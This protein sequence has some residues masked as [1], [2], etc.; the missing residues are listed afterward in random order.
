[1]TRRWREI[2]RKPR[3]RAATRTGV[4]V[5]GMHRSGTSALARVL[6]LAGCDLPQTLVEAKPDNVAGF[7]ESP[8]IV[9]LNDAILASAGSCWDDWRPFERGWHESPAAGPFRERAMEVLR[10]E[11]GESRLFVLKDPRICRLLPFWTDALTA[12]DLQPCVVAPIRSPLD[13]AASL[14]ARNGI[15]PFVAY[16]IW[17]R[18][19]LAAEADSRGLPRVHVRYDVLLSDVSA[20][21]DRIGGGLGLALPRR[22]APGTAADIDAFLSR[23][24]RHHRSVDDR[25]L[26]DEDISAWV[27]STFRVLERW[28]RGEVDAADAG[29]LDRIRA[30]F[31]AA[32]PAFGRALA[33]GQEAGRER[34]RLTRELLNVSQ[35]LETTRKAFRE[36]D[37][38]LDAQN[39]RLAENWKKLE[40]ARHAL[41]ERNQQLTTARKQLEATRRT[42]A[43]RGQQL[44]ATRQELAAARQELAA[45]GKALEAARETAAG[46]SARIAALAADLD[47]AR[48]RH[49]LALARRGPRRGCYSLE[50]L[51]RPTPEWLAEARGRGPGPALE[52][53]RNGRVLARPALPDGA[54]D[55]LRIPIARS[56]RGVA[57]ALYSVHDAATGAVLA[58]LAAPR[59]GARAPWRERSR[60]ARG[61]RF[62]A[63]CS[64]RPTPGGGGA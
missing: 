2:G 6:T 1:M 24:L 20:A 12:L 14:A 10:Q 23:D 32:A 46:Q 25:L 36:R 30:A 27:R 54:G 16:L 7:W 51:V 9:E 11:Y 47:V 44:A 50:V 35:T 28:T 3:G 13:V 8:R 18:H 52:L 61:R 5:A 4:L 58:G 60:P 22:E 43:E 56:R 57:G 45:G 48:R 49:L 64:M 31:D 38:R 55:T 42:L 19:V 40:A 41:A 26:A 34:R 15:D 59:S 37:R 33:S 29:E 39:E 53:R 17:L 63:G 62:A 21:L